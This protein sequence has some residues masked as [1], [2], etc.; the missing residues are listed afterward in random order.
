MN[1]KVWKNLALDKDAAA[2][3]AQRYQLPLFTAMLLQIRGY[4]DPGELQS[5]LG[6]ESVPEDPFLLKDMNR[7][8]ERIRRAVEEFE[9]IAIYAYRLWGKCVYCGDAIVFSD[10]QYC[11][12]HPVCRYVCTV[13]C[14]RSDFGIRHKE[15]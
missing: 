7:A 4:T 2:Q 1:I 8:V 10:G 9:K 14:S 3:L 5:M 6:G 12:L 13:I 15:K 11:L